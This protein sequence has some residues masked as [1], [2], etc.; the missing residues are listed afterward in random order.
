MSQL[1]QEASERE[2]EGGRQSIVH[3]GKTVKSFD[4]RQREGS[5][6]EGENSVE[7]GTF[8]R[9]G[10]FKSVTTLTGSG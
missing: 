1:E 4:G 10:L 8:W 7:K 5:A 3:G 2:S 9:V 6:S